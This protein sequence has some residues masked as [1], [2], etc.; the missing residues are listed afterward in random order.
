MYGG[1]DNKYVL[2]GVKGRNCDHIE[3]QLHLPVHG[4]CVLDED[5]GER[6]NGFVGQKT[7]SQPGIQ[8]GYSSNLPRNPSP[9]IDL[10]E[11]ELMTMP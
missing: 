3:S 1:T 7:G 4:C 11:R 5:E 10:R 6:V 8:P 9:A 2:T